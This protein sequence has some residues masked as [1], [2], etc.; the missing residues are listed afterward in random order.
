M[1]LFREDWPMPSFPTAH[2]NS[3]DPGILCLLP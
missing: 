2:T 1:N 3:A